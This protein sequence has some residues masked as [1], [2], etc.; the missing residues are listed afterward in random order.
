ML[1]QRVF[2]PEGLSLALSNG[3]TSQIL[4][5]WQLSA[6]SATSIGRPDTASYLVVGSLA[7]DTSTNAMLQSLAHVRHQ[8]GQCGVD[9]KVIILGSWTPQAHLTAEVPRLPQDTVLSSDRLLRTYGNAY[10]AAFPE[11]A[12][13]VL[14]PGLLR[15]SSSPYHS[16]QVCR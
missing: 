10:D 11:S 4:Y 12:S 3:K 14:I 7:L 5:G 15:D 13:T 6:P 1:V 8:L 9:Q 16:H 2:W